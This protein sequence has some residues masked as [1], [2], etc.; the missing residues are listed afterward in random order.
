MTRYLWCS[1]KL[2]EQ[3]HFF[4]VVN[5][6]L[7][8]SFLGSCTSKGAFETECAVMNI[9]SNAGFRIGLIFL[10]VPTSFGL[11]IIDGF[12]MALDETLEKIMNRDAQ[13]RRLAGF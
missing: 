6:A 11:F 7:I 10:E 9:S 1:P 13:F 3:R 5:S 8:A 2:K 4:N 12:A